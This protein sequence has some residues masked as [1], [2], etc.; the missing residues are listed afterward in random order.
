MKGRD[1][2]LRPQVPSESR[3][4]KP[5]MSSPKAKFAMAAKRNALKPK[6]DNGNAVAV[7]RCSGQLYVAVS[8]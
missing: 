3:S 5:E 1:K 2:R 6:P 8:V 7:P 4:R